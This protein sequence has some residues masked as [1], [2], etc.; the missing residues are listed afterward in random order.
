LL[1]IGKTKITA[2]SQFT[3]YSADRRLDDLYGENPMAFEIFL[4]LYPALMK[5]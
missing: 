5:M 3:W 2:G 4:R 1:N